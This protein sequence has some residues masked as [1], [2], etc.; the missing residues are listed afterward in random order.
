MES[1]Y[2]LAEQIGERLLARKETLGVSESSSGGLISA[3]LLSISG[4]SRWYR[5]A[6]VIYTPN[7]FYG[8]MGLQREDIEGM[9]S[10]TEPYAEFMAGHIRKKLRTNWGLSETGAAG[11]TGN[12]YGDAAGHTCTAVVG[13][14]AASR[15]TLETGLSDRRENMIL[16]AKEGLQHLLETLASSA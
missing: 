2:P 10:S 7:G 16:F 4:A 11:P 5:G 12:P 14:S 6:G 9:R 13:Q 15:R 8:L 3:A 1:L